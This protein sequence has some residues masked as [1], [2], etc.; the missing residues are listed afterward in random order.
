MRS[1]QEKWSMILLPYM[2]T[3]IWPQWKRLFLVQQ[4]LDG[5]GKNDTPSFE[6]ERRKVEGLHEGVL[7]RE[8]GVILGCKGNE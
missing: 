1:L 2:D 3:L 7:G 4:R 8:E 5:R 6:K